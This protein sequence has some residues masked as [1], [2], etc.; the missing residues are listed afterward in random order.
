MA[1]G[2]EEMVG[3]TVRVV[4]MVVEAAVKVEE[5]VAVTEMG[6][7]VGGWVVAMGAEEMAGA[8]AGAMGVDMTVTGLVGLVG[9]VGRVGKGMVMVT[10]EVVRMVVEVCGVVVMEAVA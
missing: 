2:V 1:M 6:M 10:G 8:M 5:K 9:P 3:A 7:A 4:S